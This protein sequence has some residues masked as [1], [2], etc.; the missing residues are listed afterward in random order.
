MIQ[1]VKLSNCPV[2]LSARSQL[3]NKWR[4]NSYYSK[5]NYHH[6]HHY[7]KS[8]TRKGGRLLL[9]FVTWWKWQFLGVEWCLIGGSW[10]SGGATNVG[11]EV[12]LGDLLVCSLHHRDPDMDFKPK[13]FGAA[14][15]VAPGEA[16]V[17]HAWICVCRSDFQRRLSHKWWIPDPSNA[18]GL[19]C[20]LGGS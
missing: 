9:W 1:V 4:N 5:T 15:P 3:Q 11:Q 6:A 13:D 7:G 10:D 20:S 16:D 12:Y 14:V 17:W 8:Q 18:T 19:L 2:H